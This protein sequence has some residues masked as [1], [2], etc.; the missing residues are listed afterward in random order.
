MYRS[1]PK[2]P[3]HKDMLDFLS[4]I[5][6]DQEVFIYDLL[7][8]QAH[9]LMLNDIGLMAYNE[10]KAILTTL[11]RLKHHPNI[12]DTQNAEDIHEAIESTV[13]KQI[14]M[15]IG[16]KMQIG[17]SRNDQ[18]ILDILMKVRDDINVICDSL[19]ILLQSLLEKAEENVNT[20]MPLYTHLR[21][22]QIGSFSH[23]IVSYVDSLLRDMERLYACYGRINR[24]PL[25]AGAVGGSRIMLD[26]V[27]TAK[28][29]GF[30]SVIENS[31]DATSSR[32]VVIEYASNLAMIMLTLSRMTEDFIIWSSDEFAFIEISDEYSSSSSSMPQKKNPDPLELLRGKA[33][34]V[35]GDLFAMTSII[36]S[37]PS[38]YSRDLQELKPTIWH[39]ASTT[40]QSLKVLTYIVKTITVN[41]GRMLE[42]SNN[43]YALSFDIAELLSVKYG[44]AF[45]TAHKIM[46]LLVQRAVLKN[47]QPLRM[48]SKEDVRKVLEKTGCTVN[49]ED[50]SNDIKGMTPNLSI[51]SRQSVGSPN[52]QQVQTRV[53]LLR[54]RVFKYKE[55]ISARK[56]SVSEAFQML[57]LRV[58]KYSGNDVSGIR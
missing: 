48:L 46:G 57:S 19:I 53:K 43:S 40:N 34:Q 41:K 54:A 4:S 2:G 13:I 5:G 26:R 6:D 12:L 28:L 35:L 38:G 37:I 23:F 20:V 10:T 16:G 50:V 3:L 44:I 7:G 21:Q 15:E 9:V 32:D 11:D 1:R 14:G 18:V 25:G 31:I 27:K 52:P 49:A 39:I 29:L 56:N 17:R 47:K 33:G 55:Q 51:S 42:A 8:S 45:R 24:S 30:S 58:K 36:K 22:A